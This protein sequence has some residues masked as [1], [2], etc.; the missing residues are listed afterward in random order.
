MAKFLDYRRE[1]KVLDR[2]NL[3]R[4]K[5]KNSSESVLLFHIVTT[6]AGL[7]IHF[8]GEVKVP[9]FEVLSE[10]ARFANFGEELFEILAIKN[11]F[12]GDYGDSAMNANLWR[13]TF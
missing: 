5:T 11:G 8:I 6:K 3:R 4:D 9:T 12:F 13:G 10:R 7:F 1:V 2:R